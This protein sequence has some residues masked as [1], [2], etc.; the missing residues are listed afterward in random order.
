MDKNNELQVTYGA[1]LLI[2]LMMEAVGVSETSVY[3]HEV[4]QHCISETCH[5]DVDLFISESSLKFSSKFK[6]YFKMSPTQQLCYIKLRH[7]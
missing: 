5:L 6:F 1:R 7:K 3:F 2:A 4:A